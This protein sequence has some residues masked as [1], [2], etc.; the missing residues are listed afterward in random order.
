MYDRN[1]STKSLVQIKKK[2]G[3][4]NRSLWGKAFLL[5]TEFYDVF[6][7]RQIFIWSLRISTNKNALI[8]SQ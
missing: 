6:E 2:L 5:P 3:L 8:T 1:K 4:L 7:Q